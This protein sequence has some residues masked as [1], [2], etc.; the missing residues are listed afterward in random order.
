MKTTQL[1][2]LADPELVREL[3][4][5][6]REQF[7]LRMQAATGA[8]AGSHHLRRSRREIARIKTI[9]SERAAQQAKDSSA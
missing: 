1:R 2:A 4:A 6:R 7:N 5:L 9:Q 8:L 3:L